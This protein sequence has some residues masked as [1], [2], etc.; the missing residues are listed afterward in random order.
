M[1][2]HIVASFG[3]NDEYTRHSE[4]AFLRLKDGR[5]LFVYSR[6]RDS[7]SDDAPSD[8]VKM[9]SSD[10]GET[11]TEPVITIAAAQFKTHNLMSVSLMRMANDD[12]GLFFIEKIE[13]MP[14]S[15]IWI[16]RSD[17]EG[18]SWYKYTQ[19][20]LKDREGYYVLNNDRIERLSSGRLLMPLGF[21]RGGYNSKTNNYFFGTGEVCFLYSD[22]DGETWAESPDT[23]CKP[24]TGTR[25]GLQEPGVF[26]LKDG[27]IWAYARTDKM[28]QYEFFSFDGGLHWTSAQPSRFTSPD[29]PMKIARNPYNDDLVSVWNP[30]PNYNGRK[31]SPAGWGRTPFV[32]AI[33]KDNGATWSEPYII[34]DDPENGYCYPAVFFTKDGSMLVAYCSGGPKDHIC[35]ARL[36]IQKIV[37]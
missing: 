22:D 3:P 34:E 37:L 18:E 2:N 7:D 23:V 5:I 24:F 32:Y 33:S 21:H 13:D 19:C 6:F 4:G 26:E 17:D 35:L 28:Y 12:I 16:A 14:V 30:V 15:H 9:Y 36:S 11:W 25:T 31:R 8:L 10:E 1:E 20:S 27:L 29:S